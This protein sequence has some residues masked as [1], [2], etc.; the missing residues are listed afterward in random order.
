[1]K[2][3]FYKQFILI[4]LTVLLCSSSGNLNKSQ[5]IA[6]GNLRFAFDMLRDFPD[7]NNFVSPFS[8]STAMAM[9]YAG[10]RGVT[11][12]EFEEVLYFNN[13][14][15]KFHHHYG[16]YQEQLNKSLSEVEWNLANRLWGQSG[17][18]FDEAFLKINKEDYNAPVE[19]VSFGDESSRKR[20]NKWVEKQTKDKIKDLL[21]PGSLTVDTR[22]VLTNAIYFKANWEYQFKKEKTEKEKFKL[23]NEEKVDVDMMFQK[24]SF[25][26][27]ESSTYQAIQLPYKGKKQSMVVFL[28]KR[29][30][31]VYEL[32]KS[33][34]PNNLLPFQRF[35][36]N[37]QAEVYLPKF[38]M[39]Y[40]IALRDYFVEKGM[41]T[42]FTD[43]A[44]FTGMSTEEPLW[45]DK[46]LHKAFIEVDEEGTEA[47]AA[48]AVI[49]TTESISPSTEPIPVVFKADHPFLF[50]ILDDSTGTVLFAGKVKDPTK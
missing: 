5:V 2:L 4:G 35:Y 46:V 8:I 45:I 33:L 14:D 23:E 36:P 44:D 42:A 10:A 49:M 37:T 7:K 15:N 28:P 50:F 20:I 26:Y 13:S 30:V 11:A 1:M 24:G 38:K 21:P 27:T 9:T 48:T 31:T 47:A 32:Q 16:K 18:H 39:E 34:T 43:K 19:N 25:N 12:K 29:D 40:T 41:E 6:S 22:L 3:P 17:F